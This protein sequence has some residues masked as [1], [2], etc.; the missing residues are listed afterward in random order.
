MMYASVCTVCHGTGVAGAP[1][2]GSPAM[3]ERVGKGLDTLAQN[4]INGLN[5]M[6][7]RG[8]RADLSDEQVRVIVEYMIQ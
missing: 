6:P 2:P 1:V 8:G 4:A 7:A 5:A 3:A